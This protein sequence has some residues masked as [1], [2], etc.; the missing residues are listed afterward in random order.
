MV[1]TDSLYILRLFRLQPFKIPTVLAVCDHQC[2][3]IHCYAGNVGS[4]HDQRVFRLSDLNEDIHNPTKF[5][6]NSHIIGDAAYTLH[7]RLLVPYRDNGHLT[8]KQENFNFC[9]SSARMAIERSF[10]LLKGRFRS[11]LTTLA[12]ERVD[13]IPKYIIACCVLH[14]ICLLKNDDFSSTVELLPE[15]VQDHNQIG[16]NVA[17]NR[18]GVIKRDDICERL[19]IRNV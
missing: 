16:G 11:L 8:E 4:V 18:L 10:G 1:Y 14:N 13:L 3:F 2:K 19:S 15:A 6:N 12:M 5:P 9:H 7:K 17:V